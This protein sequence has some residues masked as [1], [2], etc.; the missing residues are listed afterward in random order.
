M[1][2]CPKMEASFYNT[3]VSFAPE[4]IELVEEFKEINPAPPSI[5]KDVAS[6]KGKGRVR[7][8]LGHASP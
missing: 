6:V 5:E 1:E 7:K 8:V 3:L 4:V 2:S